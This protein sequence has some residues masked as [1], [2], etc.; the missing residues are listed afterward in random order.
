M[1]GLNYKGWKPR[2]SAESRRPSRTYLN[3][4]FTHSLIKLFGDISGFLV[5]SNF[6]D[7]ERVEMLQSIKLNRDIVI[8]ACIGSLVTLIGAAFFNK[9]S[10]RRRCAPASG[11]PAS[12]DDLLDVMF[13]V[14]RLK[15]AGRT[16]PCKY[17]KT[18]NSDCVDQ[19]GSSDR[20]NVW[21]ACAI[22][23]TEWR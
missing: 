21:R 5:I 20:Y 13:A 7:C 12:E 18:F 9:V 22:T 14:G 2:K 23:R 16:G 19:D 6:L 4:G 17:K 1:I 10:S 8:G 11:T 15:N 3:S